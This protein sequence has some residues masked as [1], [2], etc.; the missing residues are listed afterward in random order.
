MA[1]NEEVQ[2]TEGVE[3]DVQSEETAAM[4]PVHTPGQT[5]S[6]DEADVAAVD[7]DTMDD[8]QEEEP[9]A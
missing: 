2:G 6:A 9:A 8:D 5:S 3:E 7:E 1:E 4:P